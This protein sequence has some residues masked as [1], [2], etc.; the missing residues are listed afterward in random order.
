MATWSGNVGF[1]NFNEL[2]ANVGTATSEILE[3]CMEQYALPKLLEYIDRDVYEYNATWLNGNTNDEGRTY[4]FGDKDTWVVGKLKSGFYDQV[5]IAM[6]PSNLHYYEPF[7]H[8]HITMEKNI[9]EALPEIINNGLSESHMNFPAIR[10]RP[11]WDDFIKWFE[12]DFGKIFVQECRKNGIDMTISGGI[13]SFM[14]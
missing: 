2:Y 1:D 11:F 10:R 6:N 13:T 3:Y 4:E 12:K 14:I 5:Y 9:A 7:G 8:N